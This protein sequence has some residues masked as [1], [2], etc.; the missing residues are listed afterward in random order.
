MGGG[1]LTRYGRRG[2]HSTVCSTAVH[3]CRSTAC[4]LAYREGRRHLFRGRSSWIVLTGSPEGP[5]LLSLPL[6]CCQQL[7]QGHPHTRRHIHD[8][9]RA[10]GVYWQVEPISCLACT[11]HIGRW[12]LL[13]KYC[14]PRRVGLGFLVSACQWSTP[15]VTA[16]QQFGL[17][18][19]SLTTRPASYTSSTMLPRR[20]CSA[21]H[22]RCFVVQ[23]CSQP[24]YTLKHSEACNSPCRAS[25][26]AGAAH[27]ACQQPY[28][29]SME[30]MWF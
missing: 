28:S 25:G 24:G 11:A 21:L 9:P 1:G 22:H 26:A 10:G 18:L 15:A 2:V 6:V 17:H 3:T 8:R 4:G 30:A 16:R 14:L 19:H 20:G 27:Q 29:P 12:A 5:F 23:K 7:M 13:R